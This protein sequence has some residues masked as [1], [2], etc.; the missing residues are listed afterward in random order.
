M[1]IQYL[2]GV[3]TRRAALLGSELGISTIDD[4]IHF[5]PTRYIDRSTIVR[6][7]DIV[8]DAAYVQI[9][10]RVVSREEK[11]KRLSVW[12]EDES[13]RLEL[14]FF[15]GIKYLSSKLVPGAEFVFFGKP[16]TF[17]SVINIVHP[18][19]D[20][21]TDE[22]RSG[23]MTGVYPSTE[24]LKNAGVT[25]K[26]MNKIMEAALNTALPQMQETLPD[27]VIKGRKLVPI[28]YALR[29]IH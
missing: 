2:K 16:S 21:P 25:G 18:E 27:Y 1:D 13:G 26:V 20:A 17:N 8:P 29:N 4:L 7:A 5:F 12:V 24:K 19:I 23:T 9:R 14:V 22:G 3:G 6:I 15:K 10:A 11:P 28:Q